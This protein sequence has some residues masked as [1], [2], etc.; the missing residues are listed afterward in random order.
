MACADRYLSSDEVS[1]D[2]VKQF[3]N[4]LEQQHRDRWAGEWPASEGA[5][6]A[7]EEAK[8]P[9]LPAGCEICQNRP[10]VHG[11][12]CACPRGRALRLL[13][14]QRDDAA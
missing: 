9:V 4:W 7:A 14:Q 11:A 6:Q 13:D 1:R 3:F 12:R 5:K 10:F 8:R 2:I